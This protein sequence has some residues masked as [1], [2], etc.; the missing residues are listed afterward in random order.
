[1][2]P[3]R[4]SFQITDEVMTCA[5]KEDLVAFGRRHLRFRD[6][7]V[8]ALST[9]IFVLAVSSTSHW[10]WWLTGIPTLLFVL[11]WSI[12]FVTYLFWPRAMRSR[13][14]HLPHRTV[15]LELGADHVSISTA[16]EDLQVAWSEVVAINELPSFWMLCFRA[17]MRIP[18]PRKAMDRAMTECLRQAKSEIA[19]PSHGAA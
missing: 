17:G 13:I 9:L 18:V 10:G 19:G 15:V 14:Q 16:T 11:V 2:S 5:V 3:L 1:M 4:T 8:V 6:G 7:L 12:C